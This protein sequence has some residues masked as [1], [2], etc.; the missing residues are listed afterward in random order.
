MTSPFLFQNSFDA[1][2]RSKPAPRTNAAAD[3]TARAA[4]RAEGVEEGRRQANA[5]AA[6]R[7]AQALEQIAIVLHDLTARLNDI[8][9]E[10]MGNAQRLAVLLGGKLAGRLLSRLPS[11]AVEGLLADALR[12]NLDEPRIVLRAAEPVIA[13]LQERVDE[14]A[15]RSGYAGGIVMLADDN[16]HAADC[17]IEWADGG[18]EFDQAA[19]AA[20]IDDLMRN[21]APAGN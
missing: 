9:A 19:L 15:A 20:R 11:E 16:L 6:T 17:R 18:A 4:A 5:E 12:D 13:A 3:E 14:I 2:A 1:P 8:R 10:A 7:Q 21:T